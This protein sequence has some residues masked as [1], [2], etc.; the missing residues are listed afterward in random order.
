MLHIQRENFSYDR[1]WVQIET[2]LIRAEKKQNDWIIKFHEAKELG[3]KETMKE[4]AR[5][6]KALEGVVKTLRWT[7]GDRVIE[8]PLS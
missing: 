7:L 5:N 4:C 6:K 1:S 8:N 2:M 3:D